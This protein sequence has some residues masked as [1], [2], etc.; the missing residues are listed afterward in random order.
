MLLGWLVNTEKYYPLETFKTNKFSRVAGYKIHTQKSVVFLY[1]FSERENKLEK[2]GP[3]TTATERI[4]YLGR[5]L[6]K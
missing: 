6:A 5:N 2:T 3:F 1:T 4:K